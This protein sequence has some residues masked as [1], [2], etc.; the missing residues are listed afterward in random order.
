LNKLNGF[1][2]LGI[3]FAGWS[4]GIGVAQPAGQSVEVL[5]AGTPTRCA[6]EDNVYIKFLSDEVT[7]F[8]FEATQPRFDRPAHVNKTKPDFSNCHFPPSTDYKFTPRKAVLYEDD[9]LIV[10]GITYRSFWRKE[11]ARLTIGGKT[12]GGWHLLQVFSK[13]TLLHG[14]PFE[15]L[16]LYP[17]DGY[18]RARMYPPKGVKENVYG[19]SF[20]VGPIEEKGRPVSDIE[21][22]S[23]DA[24]ARRFDLKFRRGGAAHLSFGEPDAQALKLD[25]ALDR[26]GMPTGLPFAGFRSMYVAEDNSDTARLMWRASAGEAM[27]GGLLPDF[28]EARA[29]EVKLDRVV[30]SRHNTLAPDFVFRDFMK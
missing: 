14:K 17:T 25:I 5:N 28:K 26:T 30:P 4:P 6:E 20:L 19:A 12:D 23:F 24:A 1:L 2:A 10:K 16:V 15:F 21:S 13:R 3:L 8:I 7:H 9:N 11:T 22:V 18:W 27:Q 29:A